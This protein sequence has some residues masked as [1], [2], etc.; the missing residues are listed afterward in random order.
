MDIMGQTTPPRSLSVTREADLIAEYIEKGEFEEARDLCHSLLKRFPNHPEALHM[1]AALYQAQGDLDRAITTLQKAVTEAPRFEMGHFNLGVM[2]EQ[3]G[4]IEEAKRIYQR[5][6]LISPKHHMAMFNLAG[7]F[8]RTGQLAEAEQYYRA[9]LDGSPYHSNANGNLGAVLINQG[10]FDEALPYCEKA[11]MLAL[12][13]ADA[14]NNCGIIY[15]QQGKIDKAKAAF[16]RALKVKPDY[17]GARKNLELLEKGPDVAGKVVTAASSVDVAFA[18]GNRHL[19]AGELEAAFAAYQEVLTLQPDVPEALINLG[20]TLNLMRRY[21]EAEM[22]LRRAVAKAPSSP[23]AHNNLGNLYRDVMRY[24]LAARAYK[25][26]TAVRPDYFE[27]WVNL[28]AVLAELKQHDASMEAYRNALALDPEK[29]LKTDS[30]HMD[31]LGLLIRGQLQLCLWDRLDEYSS[32]LRQ[33]L[34]ESAG[35]ALKTDFNCSNLLVIDT[36]AEEQFQGAT[37][38]SRKK[39]GAP[40]AH[41]PLR[42]LPSRSR[43]S[44]KIRLGYLSGDFHNHATSF[45]MAGLF[46]QHDRGRFDVYLYSYGPD[47]ESDIRSRIK[48]GADVFYDVQG[49][50]D[51]DVAMQ[52]ERDGVDILID[53]KGYTRDHRLGILAPRPAPIQAHYLGYP[54]TTGAGFIDYFLADAVAAPKSLQPYFSEK[55]VYLPNSYQINDD[56]RE[57]ALKA[58]T[59]AQCGLPEEGFVFCSFNQNYKIVP[60]MFDV[61]MRL[62]KEIPGSVLWLYIT[63]DQARENLRAEA[64]K[65]G[66]DPERLVFAEYKPLSEHLA[67]YRHADLFLDTFPVGAHTTASDALWCGVPVVTVAGET[68]VTRVAASLLAAVGLS[69]LT[70]KDVASYEALALKLARDPSLLAKYK[71][72]LADNRDSAPLFDTAA[73]TRAIEKAYIEMIDRHL[74]QKAP[75]PFAVKA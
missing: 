11:V 70:A 33:V 19:E 42:A 3:A 75:E 51:R 30:R 9:Y 22:V 28:G 6:L 71:K 15:A 59:R 49:K 40:R 44:G 43:K 37:L 34:K 39:F 45:L 41:D 64:K 32:R 66:I 48:A 50:S 72:K 26:A 56:K 14:H 38:A 16:A 58:P 55:L 23:Q 54:G 29:M 5:L 20:M 35:T 10:R 25:Q 8:H 21:Q 1:Q 53:L 27:A 13:N 57:I 17:E 73:T 2:L 24:D 65:R 68:F 12:D 7:I 47:D 4:R 63:A 36:T 31:A 60:R 74:A 62:L 18:R 52:I 67:R 61:W 46:E 69:D